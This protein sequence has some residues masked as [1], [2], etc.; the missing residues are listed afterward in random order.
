MRSK[1][2][3]IF[4]S[5]C[6]FAGLLFAACDVGL[7]EA[8]DTQPPVVEITYPPVDSVIM[9][10]FQMSGTC[11]DETSLA[12]IN[13]KFQDINDSSNTYSKSASFNAFKT[14]WHCD[15][16][17]RNAD[18]SFPI[19]D[20]SYEIT[21]TATDS[22]GRQTSKSRTL[23]I[24]N[25]A[26]V[27]VL[28]NPSSTVDDDSA[29]TFGKSFKVVGSL[30]D[31]NSVDN[32]TFEAYDYETGEFIASTT[33]KN[34]PQSISLVIGSYS[35]EGE[36]GFDSGDFYQQIFKGSSD[37]QK[38]YKY[39]ISVSD[40]AR[41]FDNKSRSEG[42]GN[43][44]WGYYLEDDIYSKI[45]NVGNNKDK[46]ITYKDLYTLFKETSVYPEMLVKETNEDKL[47]KMNESLKKQL[48]SD[49]PVLS[50]AEIN[51]VVAAIKDSFICT[52][53]DSA[54]KGTF[55]LRPDN[56]PSWS[57]LGL[58]VW[59]ADNWGN[60]TY[61]PEGSL[62][63]KY[64]VGLGN[65][66]LDT[67]SFALKLVYVDDQGSPR[68]EKVGDYP[69]EVVLFDSV[70]NL[71]EKYKNNE[72]A[73]NAALDARKVLFSKNSS[74][75]VDVSNKQINFSLSCS[76]ELNTS[77]GYYEVV[78]TGQ[79]K[80]GNSFNNS[81]NRYMFMYARSTTI[82]VLTVTSPSENSLYVSGIPAGGK[83]ETIKFAGHAEAGS[84]STLKVSAEVMLRNVGDGNDANFVIT[85]NPGY[86]KLDLTNDERAEDS[87]KF[88]FELTLYPE[89]FLPT[90]GS[91]SYDFTLR[92]VDG[93]G[94]DS[95][96]NYQLY[97]D[98][99]SPD[100]SLDVSNLIVTYKA[101]GSVLKDNN[102]NGII[103]VKIDYNDD[104][105][106][107]TGSFYAVAGG[108]YFHTYYKEGASEVQVKRETVLNS[109]SK[110][111]TFYINTKK[112]YT[113]TESG[114]S[115]TYTPVEDAAVPDNCNLVI[116]AATIDRS[117]NESSTASTVFINQ[118]T[119]K[120]TV[121]FS[122]MKQG[123]TNLFG[124]GSNI[125]YGTATDDDTISSVVYF[126]DKESDTKYFSKT[127]YSN[128]N[129]SSKSF[130]I[131]LSKI[132]N[133]D[134]DLASTPVKE[135]TAGEHE[136]SVVVT[137]KDGNSNEA[138]S[139]SFAYDTDLPSF[140]NSKIDDEDYVAEMWAKASFTVS[141]VV[142]DA[143]GIQAV[144]W[145]DSSKSKY[146]ETKNLINAEDVGKFKTSTDWSFTATHSDTAGDSTTGD[147]FKVLDKFGRES[148]FEIKVKVDT[149]KPEFDSS[150]IKISGTTSAGSV[151]YTVAAYNAL[152][153]K[154]WFTNSVVTFEGGDKDVADSI[155]L[156]EDHMDS[157]TVT[158]NGSTTGSIKTSGTANRFTSSLPINDEEA[159]VVKFVAKD[160]AGNSST[161][162][163]VVLN[164]DTKSPSTPTVGLYGASDDAAGGKNAFAANAISKLDTVY[165]KYSTVEETSGVKQV[166]IY[167]DSTFAS[168]KFIKSF[169]T[170]EVSG[171]LA[172]PLKLNGSET[173]MEDAGYTLALRITDNA[174]N[175]SFANAVKFI[176]D[177]TPPEVSFT[178]PVENSSLNKKIKLEGKLAEA[179]ATPASWNAKMY[180]KQ[181]SGD[182][183]SLAT[184]K[185]SGATVAIDS[186]KKWTCNIDTSKFEDEKGIWFMLDVTDKA[187]NSSNGKNSIKYVISDDGDR[188]V[189]TL[190]A[191]NTDAENPTTLSTGVIK[192]TISD[193][194]G[195]TGLKLYVQVVNNPESYN[196]AAPG[197]A[198]SK[199]EEVSVES[200]GSWSYE[201]DSGDG[202]YVLY[203]YVK[204]AGG[205]AFYKKTDV[206]YAKVMYGDNE[207]VGDGVKFSIDV[208][209]PSIDA[210]EY[211]TPATNKK[212]TNAEDYKTAEFNTVVGGPN[213]PYVQF[214]VKAS[215]SVLTDASKIKV[216]LS[217]LD[218]SVETL[219]YNDGYFYSSVVP[220]GS[221]SGVSGQYYVMVSA[222]DNSATPKTRTVNFVVD[223]T[224]PSGISNVSPSSSE[225]I[226]GDI[227]LSGMCS[228]ETVANSGVVA[229]YYVIPYKGTL[230]S[231]SVNEMTGGAGGINAS[232]WTLITAEDNTDSLSSWKTTIP[233]LV[234][235]SSSILPQYSG[236]TN[237]SEIYSLPVWFKLV[238]K[239]GNIGYVTSC[240]IRYNPNA[241]KPIVSINYP[242]MNGSEAKEGTDSS[243]SNKFKYVVLGGSIRISGSAT[244]NESVSGVYLQFD[245]NGDG[246][247]DNGFP[248]GSTKKY[249][250]SATK[251]DGVPFSVSDIKAIPCK[252]GEYGIPVTGTASWYYT[253]K[254][255]DLGN[256]LLY[257]EKAGG[258][259]KVLGVR[260]I[261]VDSGNDSEKT[262]QL[263]GNFS[264]PVYISVNNGIPAFESAEI[265]WYASATEAAKADGVAEKAKEY[266][267]GMY[268]S[269][270]KWYLCVPVTST[271]G[272]NAT[273]P[274]EYNF[275]KGETKDSDVIKIDSDGT[276]NKRRELRIPVKSETS[277]AVEITANDE[278]SKYNKSSYS[279]NVDSISPAF[280]ESDIY[281]SSGSETGE[282]KLYSNYYGS[283][284]KP[285]NSSESTSDKVS[286]NDGNFK[287]LGKV[288]DSGS[289]VDKVFVYF[290]RNGST[291]RVYNP[292]VEYDKSGYV[293]GN[294]LTSRIDI[295]NSTATAANGKVY[296]NSEG[297][298][299]LYIA[300]ATRDS[301]YKIQSSLLVNDVNIGEGNFVKIG[302]VYRR[303]K[304]F[305]KSTGTIEIESSCAVSYK[306]VEV[307]YAI[308]IDKHE[309]NDDNDKDKVVEELNVSGT[310]VTFAA[311]ITSKNIPDGSVEVHA[312]CFDIAG[313]SCHYYASS[314][315]SNSAPK[316]TRVRLGTDLNQN[317]KYDETE[318]ETYYALSNKSRENG[319]DVWN[320]DTTSSDS[321]ELFKVK[322]G[323]AVIPEFVGGNTNVDEENNSTGFVYKFSKNE[324]SGINQ[325]E[326][327]T[328]TVKI[329]D[330]T[331]LSDTSDFGFASGNNGGVF[332]L[333][334]T[335]LGTA[336]DDKDFVYRFSFWDSTEETT[337]GKDSQ[338][339]ILNA[340]V[341]QH[342]VDKTAPTAV[343]NPFFWKGKSEN[344]IYG[345][346]SANG[347]IELEADWADSGNKA[348]TTGL[349]DGDPKVSGK[350]VVTG[351][352]FDETCLSKIQMQIDKF[353]LTATAGAACNI[354]TYSATTASW[355]IA[356]G[357]VSNVAGG[358]L[359]KDGWKFEIAS[360]EKTPSQSGHT[361]NWK[362]TMDTTFVTGVAA[363]DIKIVTTAYDTSTN[364]SGGNKS[365]PGTV[366]TS[367]SKKTGYYRIDVVPYILKV[368]TGL[369][370]GKY[371]TANSRT[372]NGHY[373]VRSGE[374]VS[375]EGFNLNS[376]GATKITQTI[377]S[378]VNSGEFK[379]TVNGI[380]SL[381]NKNSNEAKGSYEGVVTADMTTGDKDIYDNYYNRQPNGYN[382]NLLTD[383]L[384][385]DVWEFNSQAAI[386]ISGKLEQPVMKINPI[387][388]QIGFAFSHGVYFSMPGIAGTT[389]RLDWAEPEHTDADSQETSYNYWC[390]SFDF[391]TS[392]A[393]AYDSK[394]RSY[395]LAAG[396]DMNMDG[397]ADRFD[398]MSSRF[399]HE[400]RY[401]SG[402]VDARRRIE[403]IGMRNSSGTVTFEKQRAKSPSMVTTTN[404]NDKTNIYVAYYDQKNAQ[405]RYIY[406][407]EGADEWYDE[408]TDFPI[409]FFDGVSNNAGFAHVKGN[410]VKSCYNGMNGDRIQVLD[411][412]KNLIKVG[413]NDINTKFYAYFTN[414]GG[415]ENWTQRLKD[416]TVTGVRTPDSPNNDV[417]WTCPESGMYN[418]VGITTSRTTGQSNIGV[419]T[420]AAYLR[421]YKHKNIQDFACNG[422][423]YYSD[424]NGQ[425]ISSSNT[426][427]KPG[428]Y[429]SIAVDEATSGDVAVL[430]WYD[431]SN[432]C[433]WYTYNENPQ[434]DWKGHT[435]TGSDYSDNGWSAPVRVFAEDLNYSEA[436]QYCQIA[437]D[438]QHGV[439]IAAYDSGNSE[440]VY[441]YRA[442]YK[443]GNGFTTCL[444]DGN[445]T[446]QIGE[447][448]TLDVALDSSNKAKPQIG[449]YSAGKPKY[450]TVKEAGVFKDGTNNDEFTGAWECSFVPTDKT[451]YTQS[452]QY[453]KINV[454]VWKDGSGQ[455]TASKTGTSSTSNKENGYRS[456]SYGYCWGNGTA[457]PVLGYA[458]N[459]DSESNA[460]E[461]AQMR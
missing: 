368:T 101:D 34:V 387:T 109:L 95:K 177:T 263:A 418:W 127:Y 154:P 252:S 99:E 125:L 55:A 355:T 459:I 410:S 286:D 57:G 84:S 142:S 39:K 52:S 137:D 140:E 333:D 281:M 123:E 220:V 35:K 11:S 236:H 399:G 202:N 226:T 332:T 289:G 67:D 45:L 69:L 361:I 435:I 345:N 73:L 83:Y 217:F 409:E 241:D 365:T 307:I 400:T 352:A 274:F 297:L 408:Y 253:L 362:L 421:V 1:I 186:S 413:N 42:R 416:S 422:Y 90:T 255:S 272:F 228:D 370:K 291:K 103:T 38:N 165:F 268:I 318:F 166:D 277:W 218:E 10:A 33:V 198:G 385:Y 254:V 129:S 356:S 444:V 246:I 77:S 260:A 201:V 323:L 3:F 452:M 343:I 87:R 456:Q 445:G 191:I 136:L 375:L 8:V 454:A 424:F 412:S 168:E 292:V 205:T 27:L 431:E 235:E 251:I 216:K 325:P 122:N 193:D 85:D 457:N 381:N 225:E 187:G 4:L 155:P 132:K 36:E 56:S 305:D 364:V 163:S 346:S 113:R 447:Y 397:A 74:V 223:N 13:L 115:V 203:F 402:S 81:G 257:D 230:N 104:D 221:G 379:V 373:T 159:S 295:T 330:S 461:T 43:V 324:T 158:Y 145:Y 401:Q 302:G 232:R 294:N 146:D 134:A 417:T 314:A 372:S 229:V 96:K 389:V 153:K 374:T 339:T 284:G 311:N 338:W 199:W 420:S 196:D 208:Q 337:A 440:L 449:Y 31:D 458:V 213:K 117:G 128:V 430:V 209:P 393:L 388:K 415:S 116:T 185:D 47:E 334:N 64:A 63:I 215:D 9:E 288:S 443:D 60:Y 210:F 429:V 344:S 287:L 15:L 178:S 114:G 283:K 91:D 342:V 61:Q 453:N 298:P 403:S 258:N 172:V 5:C 436:G 398:F 207:A 120:P 310:S 72:I 169:V 434:K 320:L 151:T 308:A 71:K 404:G 382:N 256:G 293:A 173:F 460:I 425:V 78:L 359:A 239:A 121:S 414:G 282:V 14:K 249:N 315:I 353:K 204:D 167:Q 76:S 50:S 160:L 119:D 357:P 110:F 331:V 358:D 194:D 184:A 451:V 238:D 152:T 12:S 313:N 300:S 366:N 147:K 264:E 242:D 312:V 378:G 111:K 329:K 40:C 427:Y 29:N 270:S 326:Q 348:G 200:T 21:V 219:E 276:V 161:E 250:A 391:F 336:S 70:E 433:L 79:D 405:I 455:I 192:G 51:S 58:N 317:G 179:N 49:K 131:D 395:G 234:T 214:R 266:E 180:Y 197:T 89:K 411:S 321:S 269:G 265:R 2:V 394:G 367:D 46:N 124:M 190:A 171:V 285:I 98:V 86:F 112:A 105:V 53:E 392:V 195:L 97:Y 174:G 22:A 354:A 139:I 450:A 93:N 143:S 32:L 80:D 335:A 88:D 108:K 349:L 350:I 28:Q 351:T 130:Q 182:S 448:L 328:L 162:L 438:A 347:H 377:S 383:D 135:L 363:T 306:A 6:A 428:Q 275:S 17:V 141:G 439:H 384:V 426:D 106:F 150:K 170:S 322:K 271:A 261:A 267:S 176:R 107:N 240:K 406:G 290:K 92:V 446:S 341:N 211:A 248:D 18:G 25:T 390:G 437:I 296:I 233:A 183:W 247:W 222:Y 423:T 59:E 181:A 23:K 44:C 188:P 243:G 396:G 41:V 62:A 380:D 19:R 441:A 407:Q 126:I 157:I 149:K 244:D 224:V 156:K 212:T 237:V 327:G 82:P 316:I 37:S 7:G 138:F 442:S 231:A 371:P 118:E 164:V 100:I 386:P 309:G 278:S 68:T 75:W 279:M 20:G 376:S 133:G 16:N 369:S 419:P 360:T 26:P 303:I 432:T 189:I 148:L 66:P 144:Y 206:K 24:D 262:G 273:T 65:T 227:N 340:K 304:S 94:F 259:K 102:V 54:L 280:P 48:A 319:V 30:S 299:A 175:T 245:M 301:V